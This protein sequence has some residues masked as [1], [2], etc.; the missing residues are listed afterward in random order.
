MFKSVLLLIVLLLPQAG[1]VDEKALEWFRQGEAM[2]GT[3]SQY[4]E[5]QARCFREA[6]SLSP[7]FNEARYNLTLILLALESFQEAEEQ[8]SLLVANEPDSVQGYFLRAEARLMAGKTKESLKDLGVFL[9]KHPED[10]RA[11]EVQG[12]AFFRDGSFSEAAGAY[13]RSKELG[14]DSL[15]IRINIGLSLM[16]SGNNEE[17]AE[18][19][20]GLAADFSEAWEGHYWLGVAL[21]SLGR[22]EEAVSAL[23][24]AEEMDPENERVREELIE[25]FMGLGDLENAGMRINRKRNKTAADY[26]N[27]ALLAKAEN[28]LDDALAYFKTA[29][30]L[31]PDDA[32]LL[33]GLGDMQVDAEK[34]REAI[35]T[36]RQVLEINPVDFTTLLNLGGLLSDQGDL[37]DSRGFLE[38]AVSLEPGSAEAHFR[39][40]LVMDKME[41]FVPA[42]EV[43]EKALELGS[44]S[45]V[46]HFRLGFFLAEEGD[47]ER[48][49]QHLTIAVSG[50]PKK[51]MPFLIREVRK[52]HSSLDSIRYT[53]Q[54]SELINKYK[55]YW[56]EEE[57]D[58][59]QD[60]GG[61][62]ELNESPV[63]GIKF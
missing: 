62:T 28:N 31:A 9:E 11:W 56:V 15:G 13:K 30:G 55:E 50:E 40:A 23:E 35:A 38:R 49:M 17:S 19:F 60:S 25:L 5:A 29:A 10:A 22:M 32:S 27:L 41:D 46:A 21:R 16:N 12:N 63:P 53:T 54:F 14:R 18:T 4:T 51:F 59:G 37:A 42:K 33:A 8:S 48:A 26:A 44:Q 43:Y 61:K 52:V 36:Y 39:L 6:L 47:G 34:T 3:D 7:G 2:I 45:L 1:E 57:Q 58:G 20:S 24:K